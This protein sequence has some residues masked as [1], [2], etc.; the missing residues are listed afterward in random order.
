MILSAGFAIGPYQIVGPL[1]SGGMGEVYRATDT[2]LNRDVAIK[3]LAPHMAA[4]ATALVRFEREAQALAAIS[5]P[6][7]VGIYDIGRHQDSA[8]V[9]M[10][11]LEGETL[12]ARLASGPVGVRKTLDYG[13][14]IAY[15]LAAAH[16]RGIV[17]RDLKPENVFLC[18]DGRLKILDFG[19]VSLASASAAVSAETM[20]LPQPRATAPQTMVG[21]VG[22]MAPEQ[23]R[24]HAVDARAD[25]F[26][27]GAVLHEMLSGR[28]AFDGDTGV[29]VLAAVLHS[30]PAELGAE[31][32]VP[33]ALDR[34]IRRCLEKRPDD[35]FQSARD[36]A[37]ALEGLTSGSGTVGAVMDAPSRRVPWWTAAGAAILALAVGLAAGRM[38]PS[39][40]DV[41]ASSPGPVRFVLEA[42]RGQVPEVSVS[43]NG[44]YIAWTEISR[45]GRVSGV[46]VRRLDGVPSTLLVDTPSVGPLFW[47]PDGREIVVLGNGKALIAIDLERG[48]RRVLTEVD[49]AGLPL[50]G[51]D[52]LDQTLV[53][54]IS[55]TIWVQDLSGRTPRREVTRLV[56]PRE[57]YHGWPMLLP[58][59]RQFFYTVGLADGGTETRIGSL[60]GAEPIPV[61][62]PPTTSRV[63]LDRRGYVIFGQ[64]RVLMGQRIDFAT[65]ALI[66]SAL[67]VAPEVF[68]DS[69]TGWVSADV[70]RNG[71][72][73][74]RAPGIDDVQF[75]W[76]DR[77][78]RTISVIGQPDAYTNFDVSPDG[79]R[80][81]TTRRRG[82]A[83]STL[84]LIDPARNLTTPISD[85]NT[86]APISDPTWSPD[87]QQIAYRH[88]GDLVARNAFGGEERVLKPWAA[89]PDSWSRDGKYLAVGR[90]QGTDY[91]L[92][93][94]AMDESGDEIP[95]VEGASL[96][97]EP[98][99]S[100]DGKWVT[101]HAAIQG[102]PQ[103]FAIRFPPTGERWQLSTDG[104]VQ[105]RWRGDGRELYYLGVDGQV[106]VVAMPDGDPTKARS[107]EPLFGLRL[108]PSTAF[109]QFAPALD[110]QRFIV[111]RP[112]RP[113][114]ADT[115]QVHVIVN[116]PDAV[117]ASAPSR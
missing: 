23:A 1:G 8:Y 73:V 109:D 107:P 90:P 76:V 43:P 68:Q 70:S 82:E 97:D 72:L 50:R 64:N 45:G 17:H 13:V 91:Q 85:Q 81:V 66:G 29:D 108:E 33:P 83:A 7:I 40:P 36:L 69:T 101:F 115:A 54:G 61:A 27:L 110:G 12:R 116:W 98:R 2:R 15:A 67:R 87:G 105:P 60:D 47:S 37:F 6:G 63:R 53:A 3:V 79:A 117:A 35:R 44:R 114:G 77:E 89:Y 32:R 75:E 104:G 96:A 57:T 34:I 55:D 18:A 80:I 51:A 93:A 106:M 59:G 74:W 103:V 65:G 21:T 19:I 78:G 95:L 39:G 48:S 49:P 112:R 84:F 58:D 14:P 41:T 9:V 86:A 24:G 113:G 92:W 26:A 22:Y 10:E 100:P 31:L 42:N 30:D 56:R 16:E 46:A 62:L 111:R 4:D 25:I 11:L 20:V 5:H 28:R 52:W 99:F 102:A 71:V 88:G 94:L 38:A